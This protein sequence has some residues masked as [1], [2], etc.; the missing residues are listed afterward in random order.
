VSLV[1]PLACRTSDNAGSAG[2]VEDL[3]PGTWLG[4]INKIISPLLCDRWY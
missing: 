4:S 2:N 3:F 1:H